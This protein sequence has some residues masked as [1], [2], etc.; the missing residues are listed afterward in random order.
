MSRDVAYVG[1][2]FFA[3]YFKDGGAGEALLA[4]CAAGIEQSSPYRVWQRWLSPRGQLGLLNVSRKARPEDEA[5]RGALLFQPLR[6]SAQRALATAGY[7]TTP[8]S[9]S[10]VSAWEASLRRSGETLSCDDAGGIAA[11]AAALCEPDAEET[12]FLWSTRPGLRSIA[13][14]EAPEL[15]VAGTRPS[16]V[17]RIARGFQALD[18]DRRY[19]LD[20]LAGWS[21]G[22]RTPYAGTSL[23]PVDGLLRLRSGTAALQ[24]H[25][26]PAYKPRSGRWGGNPGA[27]YQRALRAAVEPLREPS[28]F[29]LRLS[30]GKDSRLVAAA[31]WAAGLEPRDTVCHGVEGEWETPAAARVAE[32]LGWRLQCVVPEFAPHGIHETVQRQ[33]SAADGLFA[34]EP[35]QVAYPLRLS[36]DPGWPGLLMGHIELQRGGWAEKLRISRHALL[37]KLRNYLAPYR[38]CA[39]PDVI[40]PV[41]A[42][43]RAFIE[44]LP[45]MS[46]AERLYWVNYRYR[47]S[48]WLV[49]HYL[50]HARELLP[51]YPLLDEKVVRVLAETPL[52]LL[53][54]EK[55]AFDATAALAPSLRA[56]PLFKERYRF[57]QTRPSLR[58]LFGYRA[59]TPLQPGPTTHLKRELVMP[60]EIRPTLCEHIRSGKLKDELREVTLP[61]VW[62]M[63]EDPTRARAQASG[64]KPKPLA[65][66]LWTCYQASVL[67]S[68]GL[69]V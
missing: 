7:T 57:E 54:S 65:S 33:L 58:R 30:G 5:Q 11:F 2:E 25:P 27:A 49:P 56:L 60:G 14:A 1:N 69:L 35:L 63:I 32:A 51:V 66:Y 40:G 8:H 64:A 6:I 46:D 13:W 55:L 52:A 17:H 59:R 19:V 39:V 16:L 34:T 9:S 15:F 38:T 23:L 28:G 68:E 41:L 4:R 44:Q 62:A 37:I 21:L 10:G 47:V 18:L 50:L 42:G 61:A 48:R 45:S 22:E 24:Q 26:T 67:F 43:A 36:V 29:E 3:L 53:V 31:L 20:S 12:L